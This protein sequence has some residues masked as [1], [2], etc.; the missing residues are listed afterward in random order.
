MRFTSGTARRRVPENLGTRGFDGPLADP[1]L[2][3]HARVRAAIRCQREDLPLAGV[4]R[5]SGEF[6]PLRRMSCET[7]VG[8][9]MHSSS[10]TRRTASMK[11]AMSDTCSSRRDPS[12]PGWSASGRS[13]YVGSRYWL[14]GPTAV[15]RC[16]SWM[17]RAGTM[18][19]VYDAQLQSQLSGCG[20][21]CSPLPPYRVTWA[22][23]RRFRCPA[24]IGSELL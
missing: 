10:V 22:L 8:S 17:R 1:E 6:G 21:L 13:A 5:V 11:T 7:I 2:A 3:G 19:F 12:P 20:L 4:R 9:I 14:S 15:V 16:R 23:D 24:R 18:Y